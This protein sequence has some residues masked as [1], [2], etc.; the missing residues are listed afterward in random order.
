MA[1]SHYVSGSAKPVHWTG[2]P[3]AVVGLKLDFDGGIA[4]QGGDADGGA[5]VAALVA[6][7]RDHQVG[8]AVEHLR[9]VEEVGRRIDEAAE[10]HHAHHLVE[11]ADGGLHLGEDVDR[12]ARLDSSQGGL[13]LVDPNQRQQRF[14]FLSFGIGIE[15][16]PGHGK[17]RFRAHGEHQFVGCVYRGVYVTK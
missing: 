1:C 8:R 15:D 2:E 7:G 9:S 12:V 17:C 3:H 16:G 13:L 10:P 6:E 5:G 4:R 14:V 11:I